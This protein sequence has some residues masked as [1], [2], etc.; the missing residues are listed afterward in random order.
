MTGFMFFLAGMVTGLWVHAQYKAIH[1]PV[2]HLPHT[3][4]LD[5]L[6][7]LLAAIALMT[8]FSMR[9]KRTGGKL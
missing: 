1:L 4:Q 8:L 2:F 9:G 3:I 6:A 5:P 7:L